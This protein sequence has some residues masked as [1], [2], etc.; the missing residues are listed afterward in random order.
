[1][2]PPEHGIDRDKW[3]EYVKLGK[4]TQQTVY[5]LI[6]ELQG[7]VLLMQSL[8]TLLSSGTPRLGKYEGKTLISFDRSAFARVGTIDIPAD[9]LRQMRVSIEW[10]KF[11]SFV[12]QP[13]LI[14]EE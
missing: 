8:N 7:A 13:M 5:L 12:T 3:R 14:E 6:C 10:D 1:M 9:D 2:A 11:E 4:E